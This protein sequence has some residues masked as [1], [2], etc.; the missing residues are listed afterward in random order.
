MKKE[1]GGTGEAVS[2]GGEDQDVATRVRGTVT[3]R[4]GEEEK[5]EILRGNGHLA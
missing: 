4:K 5:E 1:G 2:R 3:E